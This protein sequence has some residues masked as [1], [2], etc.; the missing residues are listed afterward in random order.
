MTLF[1]IEPHANPALCQTI[2]DSYAPIARSN[3]EFYRFV[4]KKLVGEGNAD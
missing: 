3:L 1:L 2:L 4:C